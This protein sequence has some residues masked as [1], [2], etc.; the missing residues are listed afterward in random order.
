MPTITTILF[1]IIL[2]PWLVWLSAV[3]AG[4]QTKRLQV[5]FPA[6]ARAWVAGMQEATNQ[7]FSFM[8]MLLSLFLPPFPSL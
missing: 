7:R 3:R 6:T 4:L 1:K 8:L 5:R 2:K